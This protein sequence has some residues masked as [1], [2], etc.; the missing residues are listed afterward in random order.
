M[1]DYNYFFP[2]NHNS[3]KLIYACNHEVIYDSPPQN[4]KICASVKIKKTSFSKEYSYLVRDKVLLAKMHTNETVIYN[5]GGKI[6]YSI[7]KLICNSLGNYKLITN[8]HLLASFEIRDT[9]PIGVKVILENE[10]I[11]EAHFTNK[12]NNIFNNTLKKK[13]EMYDNIWNLGMKN[14]YLE[15]TPSL[16]I[17]KRTHRMYN[18]VH[19]KPWNGMVAFSVLLALE[20]SNAPDNYYLPQ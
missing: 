15:E 12:I 6:Q 16:L 2:L 14:L 19:K 20:M 13:E 7:G 8:N 17:E 10:P 3:L 4:Y 11:N 1:F 18:I 5:I 9:S